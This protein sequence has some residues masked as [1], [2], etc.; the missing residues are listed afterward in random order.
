M[1]R[2]DAPPERCLV[3]IYTRRLC[4]TIMTGLALPLERIL[5]FDERAVDWNGA[6]DCAVATVH[7]AV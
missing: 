7:D 1:E 2:L 5:V 6:G 4:L 3:L